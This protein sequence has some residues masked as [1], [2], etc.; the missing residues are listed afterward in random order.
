M[1]LWLLQRMGET[2]WDETAGFVIA[3][4]SEIKARQF[5]DSRAY[6]KRSF[7]IYPECATAIRIAEKSIYTKP[8]IIIE[9]FRAG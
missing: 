5:A 4:S 3:A 7:W 2:D 6:R 1:E 8:Q 9:D